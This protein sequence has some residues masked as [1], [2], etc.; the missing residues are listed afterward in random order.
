MDQFSGG[1]TPGN[2]RMT[3]WYVLLAISASLTLFAHY[4]WMQERR[5]EIE[6][7]VI[8]SFGPYATGLLILTALIG[9]RIVL[10]QTQ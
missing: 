8:G 6:L 4:K 5:G 10:H 1:R 7:R 2:D 3:A 9:L